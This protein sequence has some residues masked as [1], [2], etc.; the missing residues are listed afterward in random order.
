MKEKSQRR[1]PLALGKAQGSLPALFRIRSTLSSWSS[2]LQAVTTEGTS[3][4]F[5]P[6]GCRERKLP[7]SAAPAARV[8]P[9]RPRQV[10]AKH[11]LRTTS[12]SW[13]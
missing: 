7:G 9:L 5:S 4:L 8:C 11:R 2:Q 3:S 13:K 1:R 6:A 10:P 12:G